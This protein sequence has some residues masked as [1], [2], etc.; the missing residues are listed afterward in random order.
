MLS[1]DKKCLEPPEAERGKEGFP[2]R[3]FKGNNGPAHSLTLDFWP[4]DQ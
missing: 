2:P 3:T 4:F 1:Q